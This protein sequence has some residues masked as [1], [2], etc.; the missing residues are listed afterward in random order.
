MT[1]EGEERIWNSQ[2]GWSSRGPKMFDIGALWGETV[3]CPKHLEGTN[4]KIY[5]NALFTQEHHTEMV[6]TSLERYF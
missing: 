6:H 5:K 4:V 3:K 2:N 1:M